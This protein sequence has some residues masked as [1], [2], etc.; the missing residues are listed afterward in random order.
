MLVGGMLQAEKSLE[1]KRG[2]IL[3]IGREDMLFVSIT[4]VCEDK[5]LNFYVLDSKEHKIF[6]F[7]EDGKLMFSTGSSGE[8]P[9]KGK[10]IFRRRYTEKREK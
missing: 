6:K 7:S 2:E 8:I 1:L 5:D 9:Q 10:R 3:E 4:S